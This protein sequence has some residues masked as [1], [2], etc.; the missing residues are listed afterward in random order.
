MM[1]ATTALRRWSRMIALAGA[2]ALPR[3]TR[4]PGRTILG[5][6][7]TL[8][9]I[10]S[11][12]SLLVALLQTAGQARDARRQAF[13][14]ANLVAVAAGSE[15]ECRLSNLVGLARTIE[16]L[17]GF[18]DAAD[19]DRD[20]VL[21]A[22]ATPRS[23]L[24]ALLFYTPDL[25]QH[26]ASNYSPERGRSDVSSREY[27]REALTTRQ[28]A[29]AN[30]PLRALGG[31]ERVLPVAI[32]VQEQ[33]GSGRAGL[34][35]A[36]LWLDQLPGVWDA[37]PLPPGSEVMLVDTR[38]GRILAGTGNA[39]RR[40]GGT[41]SPAGLASIAAGRS[42]YQWER[43]DGTEVLRAWSNVDRTPWVITVDVPA[44]TVLGPI[45]RSAWQF[46]TIHVSACAVS[47]L[48]LVLVRRTLLVRL[49]D[50]AN[51]ARCWA[52][53]EWQHRATLGGGDEISEL[54]RA[55]NLMAGEL[56]Q[57]SAALAT[58]QAERDARLRRQA[59]LLRVARGFAA[60]TNLDRLLDDIVDQAVQ[61]LDADYGSL[62]RWDESRAGLVTVR[63]TVPGG[64]VGEL[65]D[66]GS[67]AARTAQQHAPVIVNQ[68]AEVIDPT[69]PAHRAGAR[70]A[71][72]VPLLHEGRLLGTLGVCSIVAGV[73]FGP[74]DV[75]TLE[76]LGS[77]A[78]ATLVGLEREQTLRE[79]A[80]TDPLTGLANRRHAEE[81][82]DRLLRLAARRSDPLALALLDIDRFK[83]VNDLYGHGAG[84][85]VLQRLATIIRDAFRAEDVVARWGGEEFVLGMYGSTAF[86]GAERLAA[87]LERVRA[88][89][90]TTQDG[91]PIHVTFSAGVAE[92]A[93]DGETI[94][95]L[96]EAADRALYAAKSG[97]R[98]QV[99]IASALTRSQESVRS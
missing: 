65:V 14:N 16:R 80:S 55:F 77:L 60:T 75:E 95:E 11:I 59:A 62:T 40:V 85:T 68:Y 76:L 91:V 97:G 29:V 61:V 92:F 8:F 73:A 98:A 38:A 49:E 34:V 20:D 89:V 19:E 83:S 46:A 72:A 31:D 18:W 94:E 3:K 36:G 81:Q 32:P 9:V 7:L 42:S 48:L 70:A 22:L 28:P 39:A 26:G 99:R 53:G 71:V 44:D 12:V 21:A 4:R 57:T 86:S 17:P 33:T 2:N 78:A 30:E 25:Q 47:L 1:C 58:E 63:W 37:T 87:V 43:A 15:I 41:L 90:F 45:C 69:L 79:R 23:E 35:I 50:L 66:R 74:A 93:R 10:A 67:V 51:S 56:C 54:G 84:D 13:A 64:I 6:I 27:A 5:R 88:E 82:L 24:Q 96:C 52:R